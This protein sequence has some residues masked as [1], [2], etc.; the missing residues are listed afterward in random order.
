MFSGMARLSTRA[1][2]LT[3]LI[4]ILLSLMIGALLRARIATPSGDRLVLIMFGAVCLLVVAYYFIRVFR[5]YRRLRRGRCPNIMCRG[6]V[7]HSDRVAK[8]YVLCPT[9]G[10]VWPELKRMRLRGA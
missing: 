10:G 8:G 6:I 7:I 9:C 5:R 2:V 4:T 3:P 1:E